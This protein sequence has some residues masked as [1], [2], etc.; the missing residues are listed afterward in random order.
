MASQRAGG[1]DKA[2]ARRGGAGQG[3]GGGGGAL[4]AASTDGAAGKR[5]QRSA[6]ARR[7][8]RRPHAPDGSW[9]TVGLDAPTARMAPWPG[10]RMAPKVSTPIM[11]RFEMVKVPDE[12]LPVRARGQGR[13]GRVWARG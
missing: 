5:P 9:T 13:Q 8:G 3:G 2:G 10:G 1:R 12:Y 11:P 6:Q 4:L 7:G